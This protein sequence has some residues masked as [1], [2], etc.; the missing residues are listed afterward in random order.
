MVLQTIVGTPFLLKK[1][2]QMFFPVENARRTKLVV[3]DKYLKSI[4]K[5]GNARLRLQKLP[6]PNVD[7]EATR[8]AGVMQG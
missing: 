6:T 2:L 3:V 7:I 5:F 8:E 4:Q 1:Y